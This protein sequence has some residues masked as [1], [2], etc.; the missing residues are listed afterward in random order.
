MRA[1]NDQSG[2]FSGVWQIFLYNWHFY[3]AAF[4]FDLL[5]VVLLMR[6]TPQAGIRLGIYLIAAV[7]TYWALS[8]LVVSHYVYDRSHLY[9]WNWLA[10]ALKK[11]PGSWANIHAGLDQTSD[12]LIRLFPSAQRRI[13]DIY[14]PSEMS[15]PSIKRARHQ[16][17]PAAVPEQANP[18][19]L[20]LEDGE[21][22]TIFLIF[23][24]HELRRREARLQFFC[25]ISRVLKSGGCVVLVEHLRDWSN[26]LAYGPG[27]L[28]FFSRREWLA[29]CTR[30]GLNVTN[31]LRITPFVRCF[32][33]ANGIAGEA[34]VSH[35]SGDA[36][37]G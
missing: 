18:S 33:L 22:D 14:I 28:H 5:A 30:A 15:E 4:I 31:E 12:S 19:A 26:F 3:A 16:A 2:S 23:A 27:A 29:V 17:Q 1:A 37:C 35:Q 9:Q 36:T 7:A 25:E 10:A 6:F 24:A 21:C 32:V 20:P 11:N 13:L 34:L 8:S